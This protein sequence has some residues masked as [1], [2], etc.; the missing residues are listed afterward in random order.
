M[1][2]FN[3]FVLYLA[4]VLGMVLLW[5]R[6]TSGAESPAPA[7][8]A[9]EQSPAGVK[10]VATP[11]RPPKPP[12]PIVTPDTAPAAPTPTAPVAE[13][14][15]ATE[16]NDDNGRDRHPQDKVRVGQDLTIDEDE[17]VKDAVAIGADLT[18]LGT[19]RGNAVC[20]GGRLKLGPSASVRGDAV[21]VGGQ[22]DLED[23]A[24][25]R[26]QQVSVGGPPL[27][28]LLGKHFLGRRDWQPSGW[29]KVSHRLAD[30]F[31]EIVFLFFTLF[32][33][34]LVTVFMP[35][36]LRNIDE[37]LTEA[38]P[39]A[40]LLGVAALVIV[41]L[42]TLAL[43]VTC[44]GIPLIPL[45]LL[46]VAVAGLL[47]YIAFA[48]I[49]GQRILGGRP[50]LLQIAI[51]LLVLQGATLFAAVIALPGGVFSLVAAP[52]EFV[53]AIIIFGA[54]AIG[55]GAVVHSRWGKRTLAETLAR[56]TPPAPSL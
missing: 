35:T 27:G 38:F 48:N 4:L 1:K 2:P 37:H 34:L 8:D 24:R 42:V 51:G 32:I 20:I 11:A 40:A 7:T 26:G 44:V 22:M 3:R 6:T 30:L 55:L 19:V 56:P 21:S 25:V 23:G 5:E 54:C 47:G 12:A 15:Q 10:P 39:R 16:E 31:S 45:A 43:V 36:Q 28:H 9:T 18:V 17:T 52:L 46:I 53:G 33:A 13:E 41:P 50:P 14:V 29:H 49:L